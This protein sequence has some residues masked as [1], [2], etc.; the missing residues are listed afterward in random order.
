MRA[1][2]WCLLFLGMTSC[3]RGCS[4]SSSK[5]CSSDSDCWGSD[6]CIR[7]ACRTSAFAEQDRTCLASTE[8]ADQG[9]C[10]A[11]Y[12]SK[13]LG[14][15]LTCVAIDEAGCNKSNACK[16][17]DRCKFVDGACVRL[18]EPCTAIA[19]PKAPPWATTQL[20][21]MIPHEALES[22]EASSGQGT[23]EGAT[24]ACSISELMEFDRVDFRVGETCA[25]VFT[26]GDMRSATLIVPGVTMAPGQTVAAALSDFEILGA[27]PPAFTKA[28]YEGSSPFAGDI[29]DAKAQCWVLSPA[30]ALRRAKAP[31]AETDSLLEA[32]NARGPTVEDL[33]E[34]YQL[35]Q[36]R[37]QL[38]EA[39]AW[40]GWG[41]AE[42][43]S[44]VAAIDGALVAW[45]GKLARLFDDL[46]KNATPREKETRFESVVVRPKRLVC[47][48]A[49]RKRLAGLESPPPVTCGLELEVQNIGAESI[50]I[51][52]GGM[53]RFEPFWEASWLA[54][55]G[56]LVYVERVFVVD[57]SED[58]A[59]AASEVTVQP[60]KKAVVLL[61]GEKV[62]FSL[63]QGFAHDRALLRLKT[64][65]AGPFQLRTDLAR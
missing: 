24:V 28:T 56:D 55:E 18:W 51:G 6:E 31:L 17:E 13:F 36:A 44:R 32:A 19:A 34:P 15:E 14:M 11:G 7:G 63:G 54:K 47:D 60:K 41:H 43:T 16:N 22:M 61:V 50:R 27:H 26:A 25:L 39:A 10:G 48:D 53:S 57:V 65:R 42:V 29:L 40:V 1:A 5:P 52:G 49:L 23:V 3:F 2:P 4:T 33:A 38:S 12:V 59:A 46:V 64:F 37:K 30:A 21:R 8:C 62:A 35:Q 45:N 9:R 58:G 20:G